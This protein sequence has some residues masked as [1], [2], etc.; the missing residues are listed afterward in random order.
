MNLQS[1]AEVFCQSL[2]LWT[3]GENLTVLNS[4]ALNNML[5]IHYIADTFHQLFV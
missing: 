1:W 3:S 4:K 5:A 2:I